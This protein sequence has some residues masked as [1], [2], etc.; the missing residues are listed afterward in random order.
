MTLGDRNSK[1]FH[2]SVNSNRSRKHITKL[3]DDVGNLQ[4]SD[5]AKAEVATTYFS[6]L[7]SSS[8][9]QIQDLMIMSS[10]E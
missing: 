8:N 10:K 4:W 9:R 6:K 3:R 1:F 7:F 2:D 5:A